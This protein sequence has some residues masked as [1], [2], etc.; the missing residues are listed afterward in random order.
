VTRYSVL[1]K[2]TEEKFLSNRKSRS[3]TLKS[4]TVTLLALLLNPY[5]RLDS[6]AAQKDTETIGKIKWAIFD[7]ATNR[8]LS[9]GVRERTVQSSDVKIRRINST[10]YD[11]EID[12]G[13]HFRFGLADDV[14][15]G[16]T[17]HVI[18]GPDGRESD[19]DGYVLNG[20][21]KGREVVHDGF[22][23]TG[24]RDDVRTFS[25]DWF[26]VDRPGHATK[27]Q[28]SGELSFDTTKTTNGTEINHMRFL[29]DVSI[30]VDRFGNADPQNPAWRIKIFKGSSISWPATACSETQP[31]KSK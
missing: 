14:H 10:M 3:L 4:G 6:T 28:E 9:N 1:R 27:L 25:W 12:L 16:E 13:D 31:P 18:K 23:L 20:K 5:S 17:R 11:K 29:T 15:G 30:R 26:V 21:S 24:K 19:D 8:L 22:G 2:A 7:T